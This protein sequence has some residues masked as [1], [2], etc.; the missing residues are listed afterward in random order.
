[1]ES[2]K[3]DEVKKTLYCGNLDDR[4]NGSSLLESDK[5]DEVKKKCILW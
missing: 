1:M 4:V 5:A 3:A 2:D